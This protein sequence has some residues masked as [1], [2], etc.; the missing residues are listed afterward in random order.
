MRIG[1]LTF[2][3]SVNNGAVLQAY[4]LAKRLHKEYP[5]L[6]VEIVD[7]NMKIIQ[8]N[9][10]YSLKNYYQNCS[11]REFV[12]K[13]LKLIKTPFLL[14]KMRER[15]A[16][17]NNC[18]YKLPLSNNSVIDNDYTVVFDYINEN[19][20]VLIVGSDAVWNYIS[21][22]F[23]NAYFPDDTVK[24]IKLSYA[25]SCY[26]MDFLKDCEQEQKKI[27]KILEG[28]DFI[29]VRDSATE[30]FVK[31]SGCKKT[32]VHTCDP[33]AFLDVND[34]PIDENIVKDKL[35]KK[36]FDF[37]KPAI[38]VMGCASM[39]RMV[40]NFYGAEYQ[41][42]ALYEYISEADIN[43][44]DF[45]PY[46]WAYVF[47][48]FKLTF[49]TYFHGTMLSLRNGI[50]VICIALNTEFAKKHTPKTLDL[51]ERLGLSEW[52]F[53][54]DYKSKNFVKIKEIADGLLTT[55]F[56]SII[57]YKLNQEA[58]SFDVFNKNLKTIIER[59]KK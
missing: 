22:G 37:D 10:S 7:Y 35:V 16:V 57:T 12:G 8:D 26:G 4:S 23:P 24:C 28:F 59:D 19:Y 45:E 27:G 36:G 51:L 54:T 32:A 21:R 5:E 3:R 58:Q 50:P 42:V 14:K 25:A 47:R 13:T 30:D 41:I 31:W 6:T 2:H 18:L 48:F 44:Y 15:T 53:E 56:K 46:E 33:T 34:L 1:I 9:Y 39:Y 43:L 52:Y 29:G 17:F 40:R 38:A 55:D 49:T 20:D 11:F